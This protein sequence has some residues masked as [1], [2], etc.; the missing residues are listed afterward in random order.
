MKNVPSWE[1]GLDFVLERSYC[2]AVVPGSLP[3]RPQHTT[4]RV[5]PSN[6]TLGKVVIRNLKH[7]HV[8]FLA[9]F[10]F[11]HCLVLSAKLVQLSPSHPEYLF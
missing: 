8:N 9:I 7:S 10:F 11:S 1:A 4:A 5:F 3:Q 2:Q 6:S